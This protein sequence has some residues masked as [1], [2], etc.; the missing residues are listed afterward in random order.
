[1]APYLFWELMIIAI[2]VWLMA[3]LFFV[4]GFFL[5]K[6]QRKMFDFFQEKLQGN[7]PAESKVEESVPET[8]DEIQNISISKDEPISKYKDMPMSES[9][10][11]SFVD[12]E[13]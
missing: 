5:L 10:N 7:F 1:M 8:Q 3:I 4:Y 13:E 2:G 6:K 9:V 11:V 12:K